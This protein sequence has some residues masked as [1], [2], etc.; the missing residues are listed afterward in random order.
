M[1]VLGGY[2]QIHHFNDVMIDRIPDKIHIQK[3]DNINR[4]DVMS[5]L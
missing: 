4:Y 2:I 3:S 5:L 1:F